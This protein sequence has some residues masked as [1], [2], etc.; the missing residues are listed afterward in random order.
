MIL[1]LTQPKLPTY[2]SL[3]GFP[4]HVN[5]LYLLRKE[6]R[7]LLQIHT[8]LLP[9]M[10]LFRSMHQQDGQMTRSPFPTPDLNCCCL[11]DASPGQIWIIVCFDKKYCL[12]GPKL[13]SPALLIPPNS[14]S[15]PQCL[16]A[17]TKFHL[18][19]RNLAS[20]VSSSIL[21]LATMDKPRVLF[22]P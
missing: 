22:V 3:V 20:P 8:S 19:G 2:P 5:L 17:Y 15:C 1:D 4:Y 7:V 12:T 13:L 6:R 21:S 9:Y 16:A 11:I 18:C 10:V 14:G